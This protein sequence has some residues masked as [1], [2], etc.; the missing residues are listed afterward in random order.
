MLV[1]TTFLPAQA[2]PLR[3]VATL[4]AGLAETSGLL[5]TGPNRIWSHNDGGNPAEIYELDTLGTLLRTISLQGATNVDWEEMTQ[6][7]A[8][9]VYLGDFGN[10]DNVRT[11]L[12]IYKIPHPD[13][14]AGSAVVPSRIH[15]SYP[16]QSAF[17]P[18]DAHKN[19]DMEAM[20]ALGDSLYLFSKNRTDPFDGYT[21]LYRLPQDTGTY[22]AQLVDSFYAGPGPM[23]NYWITGA[24]LSPGQDQ[25]VLVS[26]SRCW[27][28][29]CF[30]GADF[31]GGASVVRTYTLRQMEAA[32]W[33]DSTH[34]LLTDELVS[35]LFGGKLYE[36]DMTLLAAHPVADLGP[37]TTFMGDTLYL[38]SPPVQGASYR[39]SHGA[40]T[41]P[42]P[43]TQSGQ[44]W[45]Q[46]TT[47]NGCTASD[48]IFVTLITSAV[49]PQQAGWTLAASPNPFTTA[50]RMETNVPL[51][52]GATLT[53]WDIHGKM[54]W[55]RQYIATGSQWQEIGAALEPGVYVLVL[56]SPSARMAIRL[57]KQ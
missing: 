21:K 26:S 5:C 27:I 7:L 9:N 2:L 50:T 23:G 54:R 53:L 31:F 16:D 49:P 42:A 45:L 1:A 39:W 10:N 52:A 41:N 44:Y 56:E 24:A 8:G 22:V 30:Q 34:L 20:V 12:V 4:P 6:D 47:P 40:V 14:I 35:G 13:S 32:A 29:S 28:F 55:R 48:T 15:F 57:C 11:D 51:D 17:P 25:L 18:P 3:T 19:F 46:V 43:I 38:G 33:K 37:D 36:A